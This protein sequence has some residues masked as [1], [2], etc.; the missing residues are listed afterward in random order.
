MEPTEKIIVRVSPDTVTILQELVDRRE[1]G[2]L[3][4]SVADAIKEMIASK[5][6]DEEIAKI[7]SEH[8]REK[9][10]KM[11]TLLTDDDKESM[12]EA[13]KKA[14]RGYVRARMEPEE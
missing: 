10:L 6:T 13:V 1:F 14:V 7:L 11:E 4:E 5:L 8:A 3:S 2:S 9:P 12:D